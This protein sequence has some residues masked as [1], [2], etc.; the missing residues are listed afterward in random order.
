MDPGRLRATSPQEFAALLARGYE[1]RGVE[2][3][4]PGPRTEPNL[5][6]KVIRAALGMANLR[7]G[8]RITI[9]VDE[10]DDGA[11]AAVGLGEADLATWHYDEVASAFAE[12]A[13]PYLQFDIERV[14]YNGAW[15]VILHV[16]EFDELPIICGRDLSVKINGKDRLILR[17]GALYVRSRHKPETAEVRSQEEMR[18]ILEL[19]TDKGVRRFV[20]RAHAAGLTAQ[21]FTPATITDAA[22][23]AQQGLDL[24]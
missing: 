5:R 17:R 13:D 15:Y 9:G 10:T 18:E 7:D 8:G 16:Y 11:L 23:F 22:L 21:L 2:F 4:G 19:A 12:Y 24:E 6:A 14:E 1:V 20:E 3:K